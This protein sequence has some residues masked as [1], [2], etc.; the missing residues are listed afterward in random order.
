MAYSN[1]TESNIIVPKKWYDKLPRL[2]WGNYEKVDQ[3][4]QW[5]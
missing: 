3:P 5:F 2:A 1:D 4:D